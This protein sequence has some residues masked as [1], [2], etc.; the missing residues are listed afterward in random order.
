MNKYW[1]D[2]ENAQL[3]EEYLECSSMYQKLADK[4]LE[5]AAIHQ[6]MQVL[7]LACGTGIVTELVA[8]QLGETGDVIGVDI[9]ASML[10][11]AQRRCPTVRFLT[12]SVEQLHEQ[13]PPATAD[14]ALCNSAFWMMSCSEALSSLYQVLKPGGRLLFNLPDFV[15]APFSPEAVPLLALMN[16]IAREDYGYRPAVSTRWPLDQEAVQSLL[17]AT[18][19]ACLLCED[20]Y[21]VEKSAAEMYA[22]CKIP[23]MTALPYP[24]LSYPVRM[25]L[26]DRAY[27]HYDKSL[28][29]TTMWRY[30]VVQKR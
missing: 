7:D 21:M 25:N 5:L 12:S 2:E 14:L 17:E 6:D 30:Y 13:L 20:G 28:K 4:L 16:K 9:S 11:H 27:G 10:R 23:V 18:G 1:L 3:Y 29:D 26:L 15:F 24:D 19:F 22:L 8:K